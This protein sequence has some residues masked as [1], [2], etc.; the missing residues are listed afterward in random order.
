MNKPMKTLKTSRKFHKWLMLFVG[1]QFVIWSVTG[2][3]MVFFDIDYIHGDSLVINHQTKITPNDIG[4]S[5]KALHNKYPQAQNMS[6]GT[7]I[8]ANVYRFTVNGKGFL[9]AAADG[10]LLSPLNKSTAQ[11]AA[12]HYYSGDGMIQEVELLIDNPPFELSPRHLPAWRVNFDNF[13]SPSIYIS[14]DSGKLVGKRHEF[15]RLFDWMFRFH[16]M[17]YGEAEEIDNILLFCITLIALFGCIFG[18][19]LTYFRVFKK[20]SKALDPSIET[21][22]PSVPNRGDKA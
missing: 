1:L 9:V 21:I 18:L 20:E 11:A 2:A 7:F 3:Y 8:N 6:V 14:A 19:I 4:F 13:G 17:D 22:K 15:W 10:R 16:I 12:K 5:L